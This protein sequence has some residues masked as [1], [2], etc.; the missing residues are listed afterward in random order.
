MARTLSS[1]NV[2]R[3][4]HA[5]HEHGRLRLAHHAW[6]ARRISARDDPETA[7]RSA[8]DWLAKAATISSKPV[9]CRRRTPVDP[10]LL[11]HVLQH[12]VD[13]GDVAAHVDEEEAIG[14]LGAEHR[15]LDVGRHPV[16]LHAR[17]AVGVDDCDLRARLLCVVQVLHRHRLVGGHV[18]ADEDDEVAADPVRVRAGGGGDAERL[19]QRHRA[20]RVADAGGVVDGV[21]AQGAYGLLRGE[22]VLVGHAA[23][24][25]VGAEPVGRGCRQIVLRPGR[26]PRPS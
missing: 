8:H 26:A 13:E 10:A 2:L 23:A 11:D 5:P 3:D 14:D 21:G 1:P 25:Q 24:G 15:A 17:L 22:V 6:P 20:G 4:A 7:S 18:R 12:A 19:L 9:V 16:P